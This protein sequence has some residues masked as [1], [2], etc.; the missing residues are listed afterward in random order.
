MPGARPLISLR[1]VERGLP[2]GEIPLP[3]LIDIAAATQKFVR[4]I[5]GSVV[6]R[7]GPGAP[8]KSIADAASLRLVGLKAGSTIL[9]IAGA[10]AGASTLEYNMPTDLTEITFNLMVDSLSAIS[11]FAPGP[12][13]EL[14]AGFDKQLTKDLDTWLRSVRKYESV[15]LTSS[16]RGQ[17]R[18]TVTSAPEARARLKALTPQTPL[19][20]VSPTEQ[21]LRGELY[22]LNLNTGSFHIEDDTGHK[23]RTVVPVHLRADAAALISRR[24]SAIGQPELDDAGR[25]RSFRV[26]SLHA[27]PDLGGLTEQTAF[28]EPHPLTG[29]SAGGMPRGTEEWAIEGLSEHE[30]SGFIRAI[31]SL[32]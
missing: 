15:G 18:E 2:Q 29:P 32:R 1:L 25:L 16:I 27:A 20:F 30:S 3:D 6:G 10:E 9:E 21:A 26:N 7:R 17:H 31:A 4:Q 13:P 23:I 5:A 12:D 11:S 8:S 19:P 14:P 22:A 28:F 24:V